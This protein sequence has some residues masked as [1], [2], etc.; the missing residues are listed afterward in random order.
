MRTL[1]TRTKSLSPIPGSLILY[2]LA[3]LGD[4]A[5][6]FAC[7]KYP[8]LYETNPFTRNEALQFV[9][10]KAVVVDG[11]YFVALSLVAWL[12]YSLVKQYNT[13]LGRVAVAAFYGFFA[14]DRILNAVVPNILLILK[15]HSTL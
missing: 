11:V 9:L 8:S 14:V 12:V 5:S 15:A 2:I 13:R 3:M 10:S 4:W 7:I 1:W 6:S